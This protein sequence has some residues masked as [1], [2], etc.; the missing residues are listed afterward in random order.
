MRVAVIGMGEVGRCFV[1]GLAALGTQ[2]LLLCDPAPSALSRELARSLALPLHEAPGPWLAAAEL[3]L[4]C[5]PGGAALGALRSC[6]PYLAAGT[7]YADLTT[8]DPADMRSAAADAA[9]SPAI[10]VDLA[11]IGGI[12]IT[13]ARTP[14]LCA[15]QQGRKVVALFTELGAPVRV[16][17]EGKPGD[18]V[19]LKLLRSIFTKGLE[20]LAVECLVAAE[21][22]GV[23]DDLL[24]ILSDIDQAPIRDLLESMLRTH[25]LHAK[26][27]LSEVDAAGRQ[28]AESGV[29]LTVQPGVRAL[30]AETVAAL[31]G[32]G[33]PLAQ[34]NHVEA[35]R[36]L[37]E[38]RS[39]G[40]A[41]PAA[42]A[43]TQAAH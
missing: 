40:G 3:V 6:L 30:F 25:V 33:F 12:P 10:F 31:D 2:D 22:Y 1:A 11:I 32:R 26:R 4:C 38:A 29:A 41:P 15:G 7:E 42:P 21:R 14:L 39:D 43:R 9:G 28:V 27:R 37:L 16:L 17:P 19:S 20:A 23:R 8:A 34:P 18:A 24:D 5:V 36:W 13:G 35:L